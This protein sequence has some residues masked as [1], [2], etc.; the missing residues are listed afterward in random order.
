MS[1]RGQGSKPE[2][3]PTSYGGSHHKG[4]S[5]HEGKGGG[6]SHAD[7]RSK[8]A[9]P[10]LD[11]AFKLKMTDKDKLVPV[12]EKLKLGWSKQEFGELSLIL[13]TSPAEM[14]KIVPVEV[15]S[16]MLVPIKL[17]KAQ[18]AAA[19][20][21]ESTLRNELKTE[22]EKVKSDP[23]LKEAVEAMSEKLRDISTTKSEL[24]EELT[25]RNRLVEM[26]VTR[27]M[28]LAIKMHAS[29]AD[30]C[31][32][33][34]GDIRDVC[35]DT[36][37]QQ[38]EAHPLYRAAYTK[39]DPAGVWNALSATILAGL[40]DDPLK[41]F[42][43]AVSH[44]TRLRQ[45]DGEA[46][47]VYMRKVQAA[48]HDENAKRKLYYESEGIEYQEGPLDN[49]KRAASH[50]IQTLNRNYEGLTPRSP[51]IIPSSRPQCRRR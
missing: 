26:W 49:E 8:G 14:P 11:R 45:Q 17:L 47:V 24:N 6:K 37:L 25:S 35:D 51:T 30:K 28:D 42:E 50:F 36:L 12:K 40:E 7:A 27:A 41:A 34:I 15:P 21:Q 16:E 19:T 32:A 38:L 10:R 46:L 39:R 48:F 44:F 33:M 22:K 23:S 31:I 9:Y 18:I 29:R 5:T 20:E 43:D 3:K 2:G 4:G 13:D 1:N